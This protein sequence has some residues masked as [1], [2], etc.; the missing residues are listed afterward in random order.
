[1]LTVTNSVY[2]LPILFKFANIFVTI[3]VLCSV[4]SLLVHLLILF[5]ELFTVLRIAH[6]RLNEAPEVY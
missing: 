2:S 3:T 4:L 1:M 6:G 5:Y